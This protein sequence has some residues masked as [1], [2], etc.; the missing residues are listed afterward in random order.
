MAA[1]VL[2]AAE[3][4]DIGTAIEMVEVAEEDTIEIA[5][6]AVEED[7]TEIVE[8]EEEEATIEIEEIVLAVPPE[9]ENNPVRLEEIAEEE[10]IEEDTTE[11]AE[12]EAEE[13]TIE[14]DA[15][16]MEEEIEREEEQTAEVGTQMIA[17]V[18]KLL[19]NDL[20]SE[21]GNL[22][23]KEIAKEADILRGEDMEGLGVDI[24]EIL[25]IEAEVME[26][27]N[28]ITAIQMNSNNPYRLNDS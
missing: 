2:E 5:E 23:G 11:I 22:P 8:E 7:T 16:P 26:G 28:C 17:K 13:A 18:A 19:A 3:E 9:I 27:N 14:I 15:Q 4:V 1:I 6:E 25:M 24:P 12:E 21:S 10:A 20:P